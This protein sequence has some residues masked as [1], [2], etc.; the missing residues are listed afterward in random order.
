MQY[1][2]IHDANAH[3]IFGVKTLLESP[4]IVPQILICLSQW[5]VAQLEG[6]QIIAES[7]FW[8]LRLLQF[9]LVLC[10]QRRRCSSSRSSSSF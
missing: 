9:H 4:F 2:L 5:S 8:A 6:V 1:H 10:F 3:A 7:W